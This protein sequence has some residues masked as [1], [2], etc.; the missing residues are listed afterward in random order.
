MKSSLVLLL[1]VFFVLPFAFAGVDR[2]VF[3]TA[4]A[5]IAVSCLLF[6]W[7]NRRQPLVQPPGML[8]LLLLLAWMG[9]Q[10]LPLPAVVVELLS[11]ATYTP[12]QATL[13]VVEPDAWL[14]LS[15]DWPATLDGVSRLA[16]YLLFY[17]L[18]VQLLAQQ[19]VLPRVVMLQVVL[20]GVLAVLAAC[21]LF[22]APG[23]LLW[24]RE[25][26]VSAMGPWF[27]R[28]HFAGF[29]AMLFPLVFALFLYSKPE[30]PL[31]VGLRDRLLYLVGSVRLRYLLFSGVVLVAAGFALVVSTCRGTFLVLPLAMMLFCILV[32]VLTRR[33]WLS[34]LLTVLITLLLL[35]VTWGHLDSLLHRFAALS[36]LDGVLRDARWRIWQ[37]SLPM[38]QSFPFFGIGFNAF[39]TV[40]LG[41]QSAVDESF[42]YHV[43][44]DV[45]E[46][47]IEGGLVGF[48]LV[49]WFL[50]AVVRS[51]VKGL[52]YQSEEYLVY[53]SIGTLTGVCCLLLHS[54]VDFS[55][56]VYA[57]GLFFFLLTAILAVAARGRMEQD[58]SITLSP[59]T[60][61]W[62]KLLLG[63]GGIVLLVGGSWLN[64]AQLGNELPGDRYARFIGAVAESSYFKKQQQGLPQRL[65][66][67][68]VLPGWEP[69]DAELGGYSREQIDA[70]L[71]MQPL[72]GDRLSMAGRWYD[73]VAGDPVRAEALFRAAG[74]YGLFRY[75]YVL[76][77]AAW[78]FGQGRV[79]EARVQL[80]RAE[81]LSPKAR[82]AAAALLR[83]WDS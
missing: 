22:T 44:N 4:E 51:G 36:E 30:L 5:L 39:S 33:R 10:V 49:G 9:L 72:N 55:F 54:V 29:I 37:D 3:A 47:L 73:L 78:L 23:R 64:L 40:Y 75:R 19:R 66:F 62:P 67:G 50:L 7:G 53:V 6:L 21:Q 76:E 13:L 57:N 35:A 11:P 58:L 18:A 60:A 17:L 83:E 48:V 26:P 28:D 38:V 2:V 20:V 79:D 80:R 14:C 1:V 8:P 82:K 61:G 69:S 46:L 34:L 12:Y 27:N 45:L 59:A 68:T 41:F 52:L 42:F 74:R 15:L 71:G 63:F 25:A 81:E 24:L 31:S 56:R 16:S 32:L 77:Y 70:A 65:V 43:H